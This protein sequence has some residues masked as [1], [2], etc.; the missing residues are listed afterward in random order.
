MFLLGQPSAAGFWYDGKVGMAEVRRI[1]SRM[2]RL[3]LFSVLFLVTSLAPGTLWAQHEHHRVA[4]HK[5]AAGVK[6]EVRDDPAAQVLTLRL[7]PLNLPAHA[8]HLAVAQAPD[9]FLTIPFD[10]WLIA[11]HPRLADAAGE[12]LPNRLLH[13]VAFWN[14]DRSDFLCPKKQEH[15]F[16]AGSE[17]NDW[18]A[19]PGVGYRVAQ[20]DR[21]RIS[22]MFHNPTDT[23]YPQTYIEVRMEY[24]LLAGG[25]ARP[26]G[27][28]PLQSVYPAWFDVQECGPS[29]YDLQPGKNETRGEFTLPYTGRLLGVGGHLHDYGQQLRLENATLEEEM[30]TLDANLDPAGRLVSLPIVLFVDRGGYG[31]RQGE[32]VKVTAFYHN[33]TGK[34]LP[35]G[36]MGIVVGY[37]LPGNDQQMAALKRNNK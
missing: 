26:A 5:T 1:G 32:V 3:G 34:L 24:R 18:P 15:I 16:G 25:P 7:G 19:L 6:L 23:P 36:A 22:T 20:G 28:P 30:A 29:G 17:M 2:N 27:G 10:G 33:L 37:F 4:Q 14:T 11:Y 21:L 31:L 8:D 9:L 13:H 35:E 12:T